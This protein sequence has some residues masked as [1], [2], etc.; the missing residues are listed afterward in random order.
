MRWKNH[1]QNI[2]K[3][4]GWVRETLHFM[5]NSWGARIPFSCRKSCDNCRCM[6]SCS[7]C[8]LGQHF[9]NELSWSTLDTYSSNF[10]C[11][12][13]STCP[14]RNSRFCQLILT[15]GLSGKT[16]IP[17]R[18]QQWAMTRVIILSSFSYCDARRWNIRDERKKRIWEIL[19]N[20]TGTLLGKAYNSAT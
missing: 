2:A 1:Q 18:L 5:C 15:R 14:C 9:L 3:T 8:T 19:V 4:N 20:T 7:P 13:I 12:S 16:T 17:S 6:F 10:S 11:T